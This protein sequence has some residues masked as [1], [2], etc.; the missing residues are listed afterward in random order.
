MLG[1]GFYVKG[2]EKYSGHCHLID[3][4]MSRRIAEYQWW[5]SFALAC[6]PGGF[7]L[8]SSGISLHVV[9][10]LPSKQ[11]N[12]CGDNAVLYVTESDGSAFFM[13]NF[14]SWLCA[15]YCRPPCIKQ[16]YHIRITATMACIY[17]GVCVYVC[18]CHS[19]LSSHRFQQLQ[20]VVKTGKLKNNDVMRL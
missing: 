11:S 8:A 12:Q 2:S 6:M 15:P 7:T 1:A 4:I 17:S 19:K 10:V 20:K 5:I 14:H 18:A 16:L 9:L 13:G 3:V